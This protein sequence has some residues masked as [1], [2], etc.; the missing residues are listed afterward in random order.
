M[1]HTELDLGKSGFRRGNVDCA[2]HV[3]QG[4][5]IIVVVVSPIPVCV[6]SDVNRIVRAERKRQQRNDQK[7]FRKQGD[8]TS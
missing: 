5:H 4:E 6:L 7:F 1:A 8:S 2:P 3:E